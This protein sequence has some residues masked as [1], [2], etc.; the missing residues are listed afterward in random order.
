V[1]WSRIVGVAA[2]LAVGVAGSA[3]A[4]RL[5]GYDGPPAESAA[6]AAATTAIGR[7]PAD[8]P[9][10]VVVCDFWCPEYD[11]DNV[12]SYDSAPDR[13]DVVT[14]T[15]DLTGSSAAEVEAA[16]AD[17]LRAAGWRAGPDGFFARDGLRLNPQI[18][19][20]PSGVRATVVLSKGVSAPAVA[21]ALAGLLAGAVLGWLLVAAGLRRHRL[22]GP[23]LRGVAGAVAAALV[24]IT[25]IYLTRV[26]PM[27]VLTTV[28]GGWQPRDVQLAEFVLTAVPQVTLIVAGAGLVVLLLLT[29]PP[30]RAV[31][32][33]VP[34]G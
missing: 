28:E 34:A 13:T 11:G 16:A 10:G 18:Q 3:A 29:L 20:T 15:Y 2:A 12:A 25:A 31:P 24:A 5:S 9:G 4:V 30:R 23:V 21:L 6:I 27:L 17:R 1:L 8:R 26:V 14:V 22:H 33:P 7:A 32:S 19:D